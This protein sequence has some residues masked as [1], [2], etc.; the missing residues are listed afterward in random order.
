VGARAVVAREVAKVV[1]RARSCA[2]IA[3]AAARVEARAETAR[4]VLRRRCS[5]AA[6]VDLAA[7]RDIRGWDVWAA[8]RMELIGVGPALR[9][10]SVR[11]CSTMRAR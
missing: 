5:A 1:A 7:A 2:E 9:V 6:G 11:E 10:V 8:A 3:R 4:E